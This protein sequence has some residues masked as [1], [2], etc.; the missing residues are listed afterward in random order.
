MSPRTRVLSWSLDPPLPLLQ[1]FPSFPPSIPGLPSLL[2]HPGPFGSL[3]G[4]FQP[5]V[6]AVPG[7]P[8]GAGGGRPGVSPGAGVAV[9]EG[10]GHTPLLGLS[11]EAKPR[12]LSGAVG[13]SLERCSGW[14]SSA[15][16]GQGA[17]GSLCSPSLRP[18]PGPGTS[19]SRAFSSPPLPRAQDAGAGARPP[20]AACRATQEWV[21]SGLGSTA[22]PCP[23]PSDFKPHRGN[24]P[25]Q[26][27]PHP[28]AEGP[29][30][31]CSWAHGPSLPGSV[32]PPWE[33]P[34]SPGAGL[35]QS[36]PLTLVLCRPQVSEPYRTAVR[37]SL[38][39][40]PGGGEGPRPG[41]TLGTCWEALS[42]L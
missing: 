11:L 9:W 30:G 20:G 4:A 41:R 17:G 33:R 40:S 23:L 26:R 16:H 38:G 3:Q 7:G 6:P 42:A 1:F 25:H 35:R 10:T 39:R 27:C 29:R 2:P 19:L 24:G 34:P 13:S 32:P 36:P 18:S 31:R 22:S 8:P 5:K 12:T 15:G 21:L 28:A 37:V 14:G